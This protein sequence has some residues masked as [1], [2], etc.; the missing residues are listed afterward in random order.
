MG[1]GPRED[2]QEA[3]TLHQ[4]A[5]CG[6]GERIPPQRIHQP[7]EAQGI[8][9]QAEPQRP[10]GQNLVPEPAYEKEARG[11]ARAGTG[12]I[13]APGVAAA[14]PACPFKPRPGVEEELGLGAFLSAP[15]PLVPRTL[16]L[17]PQPRSPG[18]LGLH[19]CRSLDLSEGPAEVAAQPWP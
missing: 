11:P 19:A 12:A 10:A 3:E 17:S 18:E 6:A 7:P 15:S 13:L 2:P 1:G 9:Q 14:G 4:A 16:L 8:V 5:D